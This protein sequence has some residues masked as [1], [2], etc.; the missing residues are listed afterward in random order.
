MMERGHALGY[1]RHNSLIWS[2]LCQSLPEH[3]Q[4]WQQCSWGALLRGM[5]L[6]H[7]TRCE[8][9]QLSEPV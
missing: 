8:G 9:L 2:G 7:K 3:S 5:S 4:R 1:A 6:G